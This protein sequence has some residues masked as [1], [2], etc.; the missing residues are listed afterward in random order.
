MSAVV[1][2]SKKPEE[3]N[4]ET[5]KPKEEEVKYCFFLKDE[6]ILTNLAVYKGP[7]NYTGITALSRHMHDITE[8]KITVLFD[9]LGLQLL[10]SDKKFLF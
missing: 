1:E 2:A 8:T 10:N 3:V 7:I 9:D 6:P 4:E 5:K